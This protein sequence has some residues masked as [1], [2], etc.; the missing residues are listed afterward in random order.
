MKRLRWGRVH[1]QSLGAGDSAMRHGSSEPLSRLL[2]G[3]HL[4]AAA[5]GGDGFVVINYE[6]RSDPLRALHS[7]LMA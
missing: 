5:G 4:A 1:R 6:L 7:T 2:P 3:L